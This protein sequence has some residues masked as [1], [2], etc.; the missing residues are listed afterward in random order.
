MATSFFS[1][2]KLSLRIR[3]FLAMILI[4]I[5]SSILIAS[6]SIMQFQVESQ[7][8]H[9]ERLERKEKQIKEHIIYVLSKTP[10]PLITQNI[11]AIFGSKIFEISD[12]HNLEV[13]FYDLDGRL[14]LTSKAPIIKGQIARLI[15][16]NILESVKSSK[17]H[18]HVTLSE[19]QGDKY[20]SSY[21]YLMDYIENK[22]I[23]IIKL[24]Y[25]EDDSFYE[26][27]LENFLSIF[28]LVYV[29]MI[30]ISIYIAY[31][32]SRFITK[33][34]KT[35]SDKLTETSLT[36][37]NEKIELESNSYEIDRLVRA[38]NKMIDELEESAS[39]LAQSEREGA[40]REMAK[41]VAHEIKNPLTPMRLTVQSFQ[42]KFDPTDANARQK[43]DDYSKTIIQQIDTMSAVASA[44]S[45]FA[46]MPAQQNETLNVVDIVD[47]SLD[48]FNEDYIEFASD[49]PEIITKIDR[50]QLI[51]VI[52]NL[53]KNAI[54][55]IPDEQEEKKVVVLIRKETNS[56]IITVK[57]NGKGIVEE[58]FERI[59]EPKFT[60][61]SSGMGLGLGIIK[62]IIENYNGTITFESKVGIGTKFIVT[63]PLVNN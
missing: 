36:E 59:F 54:Q 18:R 56:V 35:I 33:S 40:W 43:L 3:I 46:S 51:R 25:K 55:S 44:F 62:N 48:I 27:E 19:I 49:C 22:P 17:D 24:P 50:T 8:Y 31:Y 45:N 42:R 57:D 7:E 63:L 2:T 1:V 58:D 16:A 30:I 41:Q 20:R 5:I 53:V 12:I 37:K 47:L 9:Q 15:P 29:G 52:T 60:T 23:G 13:N 4:T 10:H 11:P 38:Y 61:K 14:L 32:L 6:V 28:G 26:K 21:S 34:L 39:K